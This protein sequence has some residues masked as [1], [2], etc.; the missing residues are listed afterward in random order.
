[1]SHSVSS[2]DEEDPSHDDLP[3]EFHIKDDDLDLG[4]PNDSDSYDDGFDW[5]TTNEPSV[6]SRESPRKDSAMTSSLLIDAND[7]D[8]DNDLFSSIP[9]QSQDLLG[10]HDESTFSC[11]VQTAH[12]LIS[13]NDVSTEEQLPS[14]VPPSANL[15]KQQH[16]FI[17][18]KGALKRVINPHENEASSMQKQDP[19]V[20]PVYSVTV[21]STDP[22]AVRTEYSTPQPTPSSDQYQI[23]YSRSQYEQCIKL[24]TLLDTECKSSLEPECVKEF[25][26]RY[27]PVV[28][29]RDDA[30]L[31]L[32]LTTNSDTDGSNDQK[33][34]TELHSPT[35]D[36]VW[37]VV[38]QSDLSYQPQQDHSNPRLGLEGWMVFTRLLSLVSHLESQRQFSSRHLQQMMRHKYNGGDSGISPRVNPNEVV[39]V[40]DNPPAGPPLP[41]SM[42]RL[43]EVELELGKEDRSKLLVRD[44][45]YASLPMIELD[46]DHAVVKFGESYKRCWNRQR[47][48]TIEPFSTTTE[49][50]FILSYCDSLQGIQSSDKSAV[51]RRSYADF[52]WLNETLIMQK[53]PGHGNL[54]GRILPPFPPKRSLSR[55]AAVKYHNPRSKDV[56]ER[57]VAAAKS[58]VGMITSVAKSLWGNYIAPTAGLGVPPSSSPSEKKKEVRAQYSWSSYQ[59]KDA[60]SQLARRMDRY[61]NYLLENQALSTSFPLN[62]VLTVSID[63]LLCI[64]TFI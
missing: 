5:G 18:H 60:P 29:R 10:L 13:A 37:N 49:G 53:R 63:N 52:C 36:E 12:E 44:W 45:P 17:A 43:M 8:Q 46:L 51:V 48:V 40:I 50:D 59:E 24:F 14:S 41:V 38:I 1:M 25:V 22:S 58:G 55:S 27:C 32:D 57:A 35:F 28:R 34:H 15:K 16:S 56:S 3:F 6:T 26:W 9:E 4:S 54:C 61:L 2:A 62:A 47:R 11:P 64:T 7:N 33:D 42:R 20:W 21:N 30:L 23:L 19:S 31:A 39:V